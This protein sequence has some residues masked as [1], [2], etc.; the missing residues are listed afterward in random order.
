MTR[1]RALTDDEA[2]ARACIAAA[3]PDLDVRQHDD[4]SQDRMFDLEI[5]DHEQMTAAVEVTSATDAASTQLWNIV[6]RPGRV[7][8]T[9][10]RLAGGWM[11][12]LMPQA[13]ATEIR[14]TLPAL[15]ESME[16]ADCRQVVAD[17]GLPAVTPFKRVAVALRI[18]YMLQAAR[19]WYPAASI[20]PSSSRS[21]RPQALLP[22]PATSSRVGSA[23]GS[24]IRIGRA[25]SRSCKIPAPRSG[26]SLWCSLSSPTHP[27][28][29]PICSSETGRRCPRR[30]RH[31]HQKSPTSG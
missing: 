29:L 24:V 12:E 30:A 6:N 25:S 9:E 16:S 22:T 4:G 19:R 20:S 17:D 14:K 13:R 2:W 5:L 21:T 1:R 26:T 18:A 3:Y 11:V 31:C 27:S 8:W 15:L 7:L 10:C 28:G 23:H